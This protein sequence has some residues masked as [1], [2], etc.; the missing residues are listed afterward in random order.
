VIAAA[1][2]ST[3]MSERM[4]AI[5]LVMPAQAAPSPS[6]PTRS[7]IHLPGTWTPAFAGVTKGG[8]G[9]EGRRG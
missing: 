3:V 1:L 8:G 5:F 7:G 4:D 2:T 6:C 9:D